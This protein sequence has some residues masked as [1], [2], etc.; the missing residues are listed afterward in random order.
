M[1]WCVIKKEKG[2]GI[3]FG[4]A[5]KDVD[6][7]IDLREEF[8]RAEIPIAVFASFE[9]NPSFPEG[10]FIEGTQREEKRRWTNSEPSRKGPHSDVRKSE[11]II[12]WPSPLGCGTGR[13]VFCAHAVLRRSF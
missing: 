6:G 10:K 8:I 12:D 4:K 3:P 11:I 7:Q 5:F 13:L 2:L 1:A 9:D